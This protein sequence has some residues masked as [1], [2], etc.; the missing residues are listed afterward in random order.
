MKILANGCSYVAGKGLPNLHLDLNNFINVFLRGIYPE[1]NIVNIGTLGAS[2]RK[3]FETTVEALSTQ[4]FDR[5][6]V[7]WTSYPRYHFYFGLELFDYTGHKFSPRNQGTHKHSWK[8]ISKQDFETTN[9]VLSSVHDHYEILDILRYSMILKKL[10]P[11]V[12]F[13]N[14]LTH[15]SNDFFTKKYWNN[16]NELDDYTKNLLDADLRTDEQVQLLYDKQHSDYSMIVDSSLW[17]RWLNLYQPV[18][19][20]R[21]DTGDD[22]VHPGP[23][24]YRQFGEFLA[25]QYKRTVLAND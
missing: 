11:K 18:R 17:H 15:W 25:D 7:G 14:V 23:L 24:T 8:D 20:F 9:R 21:I 4:S 12:Y 16:P 2:N 10:H 1:A 6:F 22:G 19:H 5:V 13:I 3:I